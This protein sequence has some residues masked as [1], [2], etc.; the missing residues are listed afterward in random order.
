NA[1][2]VKPVDFSEFFNAVKEIGLFW[3]V[4]NHPPQ[5]DTEE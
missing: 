1:Y 2:V 4:V 3:T 5:I